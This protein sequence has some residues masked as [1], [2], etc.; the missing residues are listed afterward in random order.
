[1][2][3]H[4]GAVSHTLGLQL[5]GARSADALVHCSDQAIE[6]SRHCCAVRESTCGIRRAANAEPMRLTR[7]G[8][9]VLSGPLSLDLVC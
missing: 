7:L 9:T 8:L 4:M 1:M 2:R 5:A 3:N 6:R